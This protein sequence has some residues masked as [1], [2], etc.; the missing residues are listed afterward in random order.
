VVLFDA[1][2]VNN[3]NIVKDFVYS[4]SSGKQKVCAMV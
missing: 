3:I 4:L 1:T 2:D